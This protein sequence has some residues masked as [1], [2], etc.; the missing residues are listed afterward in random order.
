MCDCPRGTGKAN[1]NN[2]DE[3]VQKWQ[4]AMVQSARRRRSPN[5]L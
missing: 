5:I 2:P 1:R 3:D 4:T